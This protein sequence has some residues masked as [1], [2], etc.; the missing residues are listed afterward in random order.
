MLIETTRPKRYKDFII[1]GLAI[2][3]P[4]LELWKCKG[5]IYSRES[6]NELKR[7][8]KLRQAAFRNKGGAQDAGL[9]MCRYWI[10]NY[11]SELERLLKARLPLRHRKSQP[12]NS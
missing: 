12:P 11:R 9:R 7:L 4:R 2:E 1:I 6:R 3:A 10:D 5:I 8:D